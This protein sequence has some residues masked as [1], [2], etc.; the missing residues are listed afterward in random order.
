VNKKHHN[1]NAA[2]LQ[3]IARQ[4][5]ALTFFATDKNNE[6]KT[7][8]LTGRFSMRVT[9]AGR[10]NDTV[11]H[12]I[13]TAQDLMSATMDA[14]G[15]IIALTD[16]NNKLIADNTMVASNSGWL[17]PESEGVLDAFEKAQ[18][19]FVQQQASKNSLG[20]T[21][22][23]ILAGDGRGPVDPDNDGDDG[24]ELVST[25]DENEDDDAEGGISLA[26]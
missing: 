19:K 24:I 10:D 5:P 17:V 15:R 26:G 18:H 20:A 16:P 21:L 4:Q 13:Q 7:Y 12:V 23:R 3:D 2:D 6:S 8:V 22:A 9:E 1:D 25:S 14:I 11:R